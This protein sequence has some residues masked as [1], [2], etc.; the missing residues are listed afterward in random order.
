MR[1][2]DKD[3]AL[4]YFEQKALNARLTGFAPGARYTWTWF[5][6]RNGQWGRALTLKADAEGALASPA[7]VDG[8]KQAARDMAAKI[9]RVP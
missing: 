9:L 8:G 1:T 2:A 5:D 6:P 7:F 4:V 3:F